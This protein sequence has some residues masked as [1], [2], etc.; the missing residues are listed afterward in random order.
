L[1]AR[2][3]D[4]V[5]ENPHELAITRMER[6]VERNK[7]IALANCARLKNA[8]GRAPCNRA[9]RRV[10]LHD[11]TPNRRDN[12]TTCGTWCTAKHSR[13]YDSTTGNSDSMSGALPRIKL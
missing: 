13:K 9:N 8:P 12:S 10:K 6:P 7:S 1:N 2:W 4:R 3:N 5:H 11:E